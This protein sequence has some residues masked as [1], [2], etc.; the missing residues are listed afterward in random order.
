MEQ[1]AIRPESLLILI[2]VP[3]GFFAFVIFLVFGLRG[4][5]RRQENEK[6]LYGQIAA[7]LNWRFSPRG[8]NLEHVK[9][10][11]EH[12]NRRILPDRQ[13]LGTFPAN[14]LWG[15][16]EN[17][18]VAAFDYTYHH[19]ETVNR[20]PQ[21]EKGLLLISGKLNLPAFFVRRKNFLEKGFDRIG[22]NSQSDAFL[23]N[24]EIDSSERP[25]V[26]ALLA[27]DGGRII[28]QNQMIRCVAGGNFLCVF[29]PREAV[30][31]PD[32]NK[33]R[34]QIGQIFQLAS[35]LETKN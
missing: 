10:Y 28:E 14:I 31:L 2:L 6:Q 16:I 1:I 19:F 30:E 5:F 7:Q 35:A 29:F 34:R 25:R 9:N 12:I 11:F 24:Y 21:Y 27:G 23:V 13:I 22:Q 4:Y 26:H 20:P 32:P 8:E 17:G 18:L 15:D 33:I 3:V